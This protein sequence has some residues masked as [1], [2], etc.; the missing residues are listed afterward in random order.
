MFFKESRLPRLPLREAS[1]WQTFGVG[2]FCH[3]EERSDEAI[4]I[5]DCHVLLR[6]ARNDRLFGPSYCHCE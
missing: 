3:C 5:W 2:P 1:Q 4:S 6:R